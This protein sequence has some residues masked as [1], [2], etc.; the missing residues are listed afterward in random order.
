M[1]QFASLFIAGAVLLLLISPSLA[2]YSGTYDIGGSSPDFPNIVTAANSIRAEG[3]SGPVI[4]NIWNTTFY[5]G[6][7]NLR[8]ISGL[9]AVNTLT[10]RNATGQTPVVRAPYFNVHVFR[11]DSADYITIQGLEIRDCEEIAIRAVG[12]ATDS[13]KHIR[14]IGNYIHNVGTF[15][16]YTPTVDLAYGA[17][18]EITGNEIDGDT[19]GIYV[20]G[21]KRTLVANNMVYG[22]YGAQY[23]PSA[24]IYG[25]ES[26]YL[27]VYH[28]SCFA[29][30]GDYCLLMSGCDYSTAK[31]NAL[32]ISSSGESYAI[33]IYPGTSQTCDYNDLYAPNG[34]VGTYGAN[35]YQTLAQWQAA[36]GYDLHSIS[37]NPGFLD[38]SYPTYDLHVNEPSP[39]GFAGITV[40]DVTTDYDG[41]T[42]KTP[43]DIGADEFIFRLAG[44]Y[45]VGGG[46]N[47]YAT[48]IAAANRAA[49]VGV[50]GAVNF[51]LYSGTYN[52]QVNLPAIFGTSSTNRVTFQAATG[53]TPIITNTVGTTQTDGNGFYF[54]GADYITIQNLQI[55]NTAAHGIMNSF[56]G[57]DSSSRNRFIS[58]Y[59][60]DGGTLGNY[61]GIY[62][63][64]SPNCAVLGNRIESDYYGI[65]L[66]ASKRDTV[67]NNMV[68]FAGLT[69]I[70]EEGGTDNRYF[71]NSVYQEMNPSTTYNF[72]IYHGTNITLK[73]NI[74]Y[75]TGGGTHYALSITGDL[76]TYP[77]TS[78]Y[79]DFYAPSAFVGYYNGNR[80]T[81]ANW[82]SATGLDAHSLSVD[83]SFVSLATPDL[84]ISPPSPVDQAGIA[85]SGITNDF[86]GNAR[87]SI[88]DIGAD[89]FN[90]P[91]AGAYDVGGGA[92]HFPNPVMATD[93]LAIAG[94]TAAVIF[95]VFTG[96]YNGPISLP[97]SIS[98]LSES[99]RLTYQ[100]AP[101]HS[102]KINSPGDY[103]FRINSTDYVTIQ[104]MEI[105]NCRGDG[106]YVYASSSDSSKSLRFVGN[107][108]H[109]VGQDPDFEFAGINLSYGSRCEIIG[110]EIT[111]PD[112][113]Y[114]ILSSYSNYNVIANNM[115][116]GCEYSGIKSGGGF[117]D[118]IYYNSVLNS[119]HSALYMVSR[120]ATLKNNILYQTGS[121]SAYAI[122]VQGGVTLPTASDYNDLYAPLGLVGYYLGSRTTLADWQ[123]GTSRDLHSISADPNFIS[124]S[125]PIDLHL[126]EPSPA[127]GTGTPV[128]EIT[129]D[130]DGDLRDEFTPDIGADE[131]LPAGPPEAVDDLVITLSSSTDDSTNITLIWSPV[132]GAVQYHVYKS[133]TGPAGGYMLIGS[134]ATTTYTDTSAIIGETK[135][136]YY[137]TADNE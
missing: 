98:G 133:I 27:L 123:A 29:D 104:G 132:V 43:P 100:N 111:G 66:T 72:Y 17:D 32:H 112:I 70:Y 49:F 61:A 92:N 10:F 47:H 42:R 114:G 90:V 78:D 11:I 121:G 67:A 25:Y 55:T 71:Y 39:L 74:L 127:L 19:W 69:G 109:D 15:G 6:Q 116:Y 38:T 108:I 76:V 54:T 36:S 7:V 56:T 128:A 64:N 82:Q 120:S 60:H 2:Q 5:E 12:S 41:Q 115:I 28:N 58:N 48:P 113:Y 130:F 126:N 91:L 99:T 105:R 135:S 30:G 53:Q 24:C 122:Y 80:T 16:T 101:G 87:F 84:H 9:S 62:L 136:F 63:L 18:C 37:A 89:E 21:C 75:H 14:I 125:A 3:V 102:P 93:Y 106:I 51:S 129:D 57:T 33:Y 81:L 20:Y 34:Y 44:S 52:G 22:C 83:P 46:A 117:Y 134:T 79:N 131:F 1:R 8:N 88:P 124:I 96:E 86:D 50:S 59:I 35:D 23:Y 118:G 68:Y 77:L 85:I 119:V 45:D 4:C 97:A 110:N 31:N 40:A 65:Q 94:M 26:A 103:G 73:D 13:C 95:N 107:Y 137:V